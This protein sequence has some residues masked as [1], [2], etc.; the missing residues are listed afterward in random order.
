MNF[1]VR[2]IVSVSAVVLFAQGARGEGRVE[3]SVVLTPAGSFKAVT[4]DVTGQAYKT[5]DGVAADNVTVS[6]KS[7]T[8]GVSLRDKHTK[9]HLMVGKFPEAKLL[10]AS[11]KNGKGTATVEVKGQRHAVEG[12]YV[13]EGETLKAQFPMQ[14]SDLDIKDVRY[15]GIGVK[16]AVKVLVELPLVSAAKGSGMGSKGK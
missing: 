13:I 12:T 6:L 3:I 2:G 4:S 14:L 10:K 11:G 16:D 5:G 1:I 7:L 15:M 8:T 9:E